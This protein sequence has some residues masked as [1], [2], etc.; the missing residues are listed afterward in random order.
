MI[1]VTTADGTDTFEIGMENTV[2]GQYY[3]QKNEEDILYLI[4]GSFPSVFEK[5]LED[6]EAVSEET[7][8]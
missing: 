1:T 4:P 5:T 8:E 7:E 2:T 3:L 6:L